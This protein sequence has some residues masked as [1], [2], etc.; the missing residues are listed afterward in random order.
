[1]RWQAPVSAGVSFLK[2]DNCFTAGEPDVA[3]RFAAM[4]D[5]LNAT[6]QPILYSLCEWVCGVLAVR[7]TAGRALPAGRPGCSAS[8]SATGLLRAAGHCRS[9]AL[10]P[11]RVPLLADHLR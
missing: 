7:G 6:G 2:Y 10:G 5:A 8:I 11:V 9:V 3:Q 4:R 1:M